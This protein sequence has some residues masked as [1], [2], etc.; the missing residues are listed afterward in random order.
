[1]THIKDHYHNVTDDLPSGVLLAH[2]AE[3]NGENDYLLL[4]EDGI[5]HRWG[6]SI[7]QVQGQT[8]SPLT[9]AEVEKAKKST[10]L[11][12]DFNVWY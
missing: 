11:F 1:M 3:G 8:F 5:A 10:C 12:S 6:K 7:R 4:Y 2:M 9:P